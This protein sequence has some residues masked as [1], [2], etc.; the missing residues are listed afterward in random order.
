MSKFIRT[1]IGLVIIGFCFNAYSAQ[2]PMRPPSWT[3]RSPAPDAA[4]AESLSLQ[5][6]LI[7][8]TRKIAIINEKIVTEGASV[9]GARIIEITDEWVRVK[10]RGRSMTLKVAPMTK[11]YSREK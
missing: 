2:D 3:T 7:S 9:S 11:E 1:A 10:R 4:N 8:S 5:Q 6:I